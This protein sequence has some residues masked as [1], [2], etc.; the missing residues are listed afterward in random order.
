MLEADAMARAGGLVYVNDGDP[1]IRR[2]RRGKSFVYVD[3]DGRRVTD[4][5]TLDRI[6]KL[7]IPPA[8]E[9]VWICTD[10]LGHLQARGA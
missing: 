7:A 8:Y 6:A 5:V 3:R 4:T 9:D 2:V 10:E 1:G